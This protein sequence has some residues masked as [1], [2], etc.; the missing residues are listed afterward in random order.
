MGDSQAPRLPGE[1]A[2][3]SRRDL[4]KIR[5]RGDID[6]TGDNFKSMTYLAGMTAVCRNRLFVP[7]RGR[8]SSKRCTGNFEDPPRRRRRDARTHRR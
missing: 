4:T 2:R 6:F 8:N 7:K 1:T 5:E 3:G